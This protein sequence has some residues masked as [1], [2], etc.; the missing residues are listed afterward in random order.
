[1]HHING[2]LNAPNLHITALLQH[3]QYLSLHHL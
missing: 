2:C 1:M 3:M